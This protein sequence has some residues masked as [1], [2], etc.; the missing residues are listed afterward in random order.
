MA[1]GAPVDSQNPDELLALHC[2]FVL[3][4]GRP[5]AC[6]I[7]V[8]WLTNCSHLF[9]AE[10]AKE[11]FA[12]NVDCP[13][14]HGSGAVRVLKVDFNRPSKERNLA[15]MGFL[16]SQVFQ[17]ASEAFGFWAQQKMLEHDWQ[18]EVSKKSQ[19]REARLRGT[20]QERAR[21]VSKVIEALTQKKTKL[22]QQ[23][24]E[25]LAHGEQLK[26]QAAEVSARLVHV[27]RCCTMLQ[28]ADDGWKAAPSWRRELR[29][30][31]APIAEH[32]A[33]P[34]GGSGAAAS[35]APGASPDFTGA[36]VG[37]RR[38]NSILFASG[39]NTASVGVQR[40]APPGLAGSDGRSLRRR[41]K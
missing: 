18:A 6:R 3:L 35:V 28:A 12:S 25:M 16:P 1:L 22:K 27:Q 20:Y 37:L 34:V 36:K 2:N 41:M 40:P 24:R 7:D 15:M 26:E 29:G 38:R 13:V 4:N 23:L 14:C 5:C 8:G 31:C 19:V 33:G 30:V 17:A 10:H 11:W 32:S 9:C 21:E 39:I